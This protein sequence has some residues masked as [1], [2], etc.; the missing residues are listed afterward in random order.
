MASPFIFLLSSTK[1]LEAFASSTHSQNN[2]TI[3]TP[4]DSNKVYCIGKCVAS[5][6]PECPHSEPSSVGLDKMWPIGILSDQQDRETLLAYDVHFLEATRIALYW[7]FSHE[8]NVTLPSEKTNSQR[9]LTSFC[10]ILRHIPYERQI[11][12]P[13][14]L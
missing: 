9:W 11:L 1:I 12:V 3:F 14:W 13:R 7:A 6:Y 2:K 4:A 5:Y 8:E 10:S